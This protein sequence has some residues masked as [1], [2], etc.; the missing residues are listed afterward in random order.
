MVETDNLVMRHA[1][2]IDNIQIKERWLL[3]YIGCTVIGVAFSPGGHMLASVGSDT[4]VRLWDAE[5]GRHWSQFA[6]RDVNFSPD[7]RLLA[8]ID[9][10]GKAQLWE[11]SRGQGLRRLDGPDM[12]QVVFSPDGSRV[13]GVSTGSLRD[14][15]LVWGV[16]G[17]RRT[18]RMQGI[19]YGMNNVAFSPNGQFLAGGSKKIRVWHVETGEIWRE[20]TGHDDQIEAMAFSPNGRLLATGSRDHTVRLWDIESGHE[21]NRLN[22]HNGEVHSVAFHPGGGVLASGSWDTTIRLWDVFTGLLLACLTSHKSYV[23]SVTFSP[24]GRWLA[25]GSWDKTVRLWPLAVSDETWVHQARLWRNQHTHEWQL[26]HR[27]EVCGEGIGLWFRWQGHT[28]CREH[29]G[30]P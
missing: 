30:Q 4:L 20:F 25:S 15:V 12:G 3:K 23:Q 7:G 14:K 26:M 16:N 2:T 13:A 5:T 28:R 17:Q 22:G 27:C 6:G 19:S 21:I 29:R 8:S 11:I 10:Q 1:A 24:D 18:H 9:R